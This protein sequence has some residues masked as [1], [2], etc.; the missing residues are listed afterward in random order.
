M[1]GATT[2]PHIPHFPFSWHIFPTTPPLPLLPEIT[3]KFNPLAVASQKED[4]DF[5]MC[6]RSIVFLWAQAPNLS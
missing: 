5:K 3:F 6:Q 4:V 1:Q 2:P